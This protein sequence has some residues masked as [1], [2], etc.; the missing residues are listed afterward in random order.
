VGAAGTT[1]TAAGEGARRR[2]TS[3]AL[4]LWA[5]S[6]R[7]VE[8]ARTASQAFPQSRKRSVF[9]GARRVGAA[10]TTVTAA[11]EGARQDV[12]TATSGQRRADSGP[13][14]W[15]VG[16]AGTTVTAAGEG[17]RRRV[18]SDA[19]RLWAGSGRTVEPAR[20]RVRLSPRS[21]KRSVFCGA[22][23]VGTAGTTVTAASEGARQNVPTATSGQR[24]ADSGPA[25][26][27][28]GAVWHHCDG[29]K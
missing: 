16:A 24:R 20:T 13:A 25:R 1:V 6:G 21:R 5:G 4:R 26:W 14:R 11:G 22:R 27:R 28:V 7:T 29:S 8:P 17:A 9:C 23:R 12:P 10:G 15:R 19:L 3:D 18:T 2:V